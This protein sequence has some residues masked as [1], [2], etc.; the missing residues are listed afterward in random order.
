MDGISC[1]GDFLE[2]LVVSTD[3]RYTAPTALMMIEL[4]SA[5]LGS[6][7]L[8]TEALWQAVLGVTYQYTSGHLPELLYS[9]YC[10]FLKVCL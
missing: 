8:P 7:Q 3:A 2:L 1:C 9:D 5:Q 4:L 10:S 6:R